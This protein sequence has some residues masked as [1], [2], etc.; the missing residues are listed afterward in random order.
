[1]RYLTEAVTKVLR[2]S[3]IPARPCLAHLL[4]QRVHQATHS[5]IDGVSDVLQV[6]SVCLRDKQLEEGTVSGRER[7]WYDIHHVWYNLI[8][9]CCSGTIQSVCILQMAFPYPWGYTCDAR[10]WNGSPTLSGELYMCRNCRMCGNQDKYIYMTQKSSWWFCS[11]W[12]MSSILKDYHPK[13]GTLGSGPSHPHTFGLWPCSFWSDVSQPSWSSFSGDTPTYLVSTVDRNPVWF[14]IM[15][16]Q[17]AHDDACMCMLPH[18]ECHIL[19]FPRRAK[20]HSRL[21][22]LM[23][24]RAHMT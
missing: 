4:N 20:D 7:A 16:V 3:Q 11:L 17:I 14:G 2:N 23:S 21:H 1:M 5:W 8:N 12:L 10:S 19:G 22:I 18:S 15:M 24:I 13:F 9:S 6:V